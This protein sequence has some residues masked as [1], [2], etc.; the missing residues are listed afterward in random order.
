MLAFSQWTVGRH[1]GL[2]RNTQGDHVANENMEFVGERLIEDDFVVSRR[3]VGR[4][5][6]ERPKG[7]LNAQQRHL[8]C[9]EGIVFGN[10]LL[11]EY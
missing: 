10:G 6:P 5:R 2:R 4:D 8:T 7:W 11:D 9:Y 1:N 3:D